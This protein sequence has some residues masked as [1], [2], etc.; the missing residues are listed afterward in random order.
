MCCPWWSVILIKQEKLSKISSGSALDY[1]RAY[2]QRPHLWNRIKPTVFEQRLGGGPAAIH[3]VPEYQNE[4][5]LTLEPSTTDCPKH[6]TEFS[7][8]PSWHSRVQRQHWPQRVCPSVGKTEAWVSFLAT[9]SMFLRKGAQSLG[10]SIDLCMATMDFS[11][12]CLSILRTSS[13]KKYL[14]QASPPE[15][16]ARFLES[17]TQ[18]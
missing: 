6:Q 3:D 16:W 11:S 7:A 5:L 14:Q 15:D 12:S 13:Q 2:G 4:G 18:G 17:F 8:E 1:C 9:E 10:E